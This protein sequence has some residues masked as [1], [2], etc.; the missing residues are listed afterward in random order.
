VAQSS[1]EQR[2]ESSELSREG[3]DKLDQGGQRGREASSHGFF[4][5][6]GKGPFGL[7]RRMMG[8]MER[9]FES[10]GLDPMKIAAW[11][12]S[13]EV[14]QREREGEL[15]IKAKL[16]DLTQD[17]IEVRMVDGALKIEGERR[18]EHRE[19][20]G[21]YQ[22]MERSRF[23]RSIGIPKGVSVEDIDAQFHEG[24]LEIRVALPEHLR[25]RRIPIKGSA[26]GGTVTSEAMSGS[27]AS[28]NPESAPERAAAA[29]SANG[30]P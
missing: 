22:Y 13:I 6:G 12:P 16:P 10:I 7:M 25:S 26:G 4:G 28:P 21:G 15:L 14:Q 3:R 23:S 19:E 30:Q 18:R 27:A 1:D 5:L 17:D 11:S 29:A 20:R 24:M 8:D 9:M 2:R